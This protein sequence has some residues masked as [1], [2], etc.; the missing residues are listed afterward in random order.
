MSVFSPYLQNSGK[1]TMYSELL[2]RNLLHENLIQDL[3]NHAYI[4]LIL[5]INAEETDVLNVA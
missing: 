1:K 5:Q 2:L 3:S 4:C